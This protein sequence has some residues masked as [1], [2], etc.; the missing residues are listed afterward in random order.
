M[1]ALTRA[2]SSQP[3]T[4]RLRRPYPDWLYNAL[5]F[6]YLWGGFGVIV[7][8][9]GWLSVF[10]GLTLM[11]AAGV[12]WMYREHNRRC[13]ALQPPGDKVRTEDAE[14][15][16]VMVNADD[17]GAA[18]VGA[19]RNPAPVRQAPAWVPDE[20]ALAFEVPAALT[21]DVMPAPDAPC[22]LLAA[23]ETAWRK[24]IECGVPTLDAQRLGLFTLCH[25]LLEIVMDKAPRSE[26]QSMLD[27]FADQISD[28]LSTEGEVLAKVNRPL[29]TQSQEQRNA[30]R[31][32][33]N[34]FRDCFN[35]GAW[36]VNEFIRFATYD[37][38]AVHL[39]GACLSAYAGPRSAEK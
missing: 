36:N 32:K 6:L 7:L 33:A 27:R 3:T 16:V 20:Q 34:G 28:H 8:L 18:A 38:I 35:G 1:N 39:A 17:S 10:S 22:P 30:M 31:V 21:A 23:K 25:E 15:A 29:S 37:V 12:V 5:P 11:S 14:S 13:L 9:P 2:G 26:T 19:I 4:S 24:S